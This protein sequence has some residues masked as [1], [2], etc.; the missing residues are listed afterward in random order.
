MTLLRVPVLYSFL[1]LFLSLI[2]FRFVK[3]DKPLFICFAALLLFLFTV[4]TFGA[5]FFLLIYSTVYTRN[6]VNTDLPVLTL[7]NPNNKFWGDFILGLSEFCCKPALSNFSTPECV[8][9]EL[10]LYEEETKFCRETTSSFIRGKIFARNLNLCSF[11]W[12]DSL[13]VSETV[14]NE[15]VRNLIWDFVRETCQVTD[16]IGGGV[17][18]CFIAFS[19]LLFIISFLDLVVAFRSV[20]L[21]NTSQAEEREP[22]ELKETSSNNQDE[23]SNN[24]SFENTSSA[25]ETSETKI[26]IT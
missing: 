22:V 4:C 17:S 25:P 20:L 6:I 23:N 1:S 2:G 3:D 8:L 14:S 10:D 5:G 18:L 21:K 24:T 13:C 11:S 19:V 9:V 7:E 12:F 15:R 26:E 16:R